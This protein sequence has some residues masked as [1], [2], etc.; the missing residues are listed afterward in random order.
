MLVS[1]VLFDGTYIG[2]DNFTFLLDVNCCM[3]PTVITAPTV[4][5]TAFTYRVSD[6][7]MAIALSGEWQGDNSCCSIPA[8]SP[9]I[10]PAPPAG[11]FTVSADNLSVTVYTTD[12]SGTGPVGQTYTITV[13]AE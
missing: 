1:G 5:S 13:T 11:L 6:P 7:A 4:S 10:S 12:L 2:Q 3:S 9:T 8:A